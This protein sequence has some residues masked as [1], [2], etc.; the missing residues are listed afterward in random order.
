MV[1]HGYQYVNIDDCWSVQ[2]G[3]EGPDLR[4]EPRDAERHDQRQ[5]PFPR[6]EGPDRLHPRQGPQ[7]RHLHLARPDDLRRVTSRAWQHEEQD[8]A[9]LR[10]VGLRLPEVRLVLLRRRRQGAERRGAPEALPAHQRHPGRSSRATSSS[11]SASTAWAR[12][13]SGARAVGG[14]SWRTAGDLGGSF[15]GI[16]GSLFRD[17]FDVYSENELHRYGGPGGW[18]DPDYLLIGYLSD[19]KGR[20]GAD[21]AHAERAVHPRLALVA[22]RGAAHLQR[23]HHPPRRL[24]A[25]P[26]HQRRDH[27]RRPGPARQ[28]R[29]A[30]REDRRPRGL[31]PRAGGRLEGRRAL[32]PRRRPGRRSRRHGPTSASRA[33]R[34]S[35]ISGARRTSASIDGALHGLRRPPRRRVNSRRHAEEAVTRIRFPLTSGALWYP[36]DS[37]LRP[38]T[39]PRQRPC[40]ESEKAVTSSYRSASSAGSPS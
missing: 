2:P 13:G 1:D 11:T 7:G 32:Q 6:H 12:S 21:A 23:R 26:P 40:Q 19:W 22:R 10:R 4:G 16:A 36:P 34:R 31:G 18:N 29:P 25:R 8:V 5:R 38:R 24:H 39:H 9:P 3:R 28:A 20:H 17:G 37:S 30:R 14:H 15:E 33:R 27:R 35:A